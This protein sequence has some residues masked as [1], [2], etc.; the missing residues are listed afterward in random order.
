[1]Y[2]VTTSK[3]TGLNSCYLQSSFTTMLLVL[4][5]MSLYSSL[6]RNIIQ[7]SLFT[8]NIILLFSKPMLQILMSYKVLSKPKSLWPNSVIRNLL[9]HNVLLLLISK[10]VIK[11]LSR[12]SSFKP[13]G[14]QKNSLK[15]ISDP[16]KSS[17]SLAL[18]LLLSVF[19]SPCALFIQFSMCPCLNLPHPTFSPREYNWP[20]LQS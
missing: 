3:I 15:N 13:L 7:T 6:I 10:Q 9:M 19:Q 5:L 20:L 17:L 11:S 1:M 4:P 16:M 12:L 18:Y 8:L 14:L 2:I